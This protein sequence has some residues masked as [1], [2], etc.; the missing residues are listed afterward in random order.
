MIFFDEGV[1]A[2]RKL[3]GSAS[4][5]VVD[6]LSSP[7]ISFALVPYL[8][9][10]MGKEQYGVWILSISFLGLMQFVSLGSSA[11]LITEISHRQHSSRQ[12]SVEGLI[13]CSLAIALCGSAVLMILVWAATPFLPPG[14][15]GW[16]SDS[17]VQQVVLIAAVISVSEIDNIF[18]N[19]LRGLARFDVAARI[20]LI[21]RVIWALAV[22]IVTA[23]DGSAIGVLFVTLCLTLFKAGVKACALQQMLGSHMPIWRPKFSR[24]DAYILVSFGGWALIHALAGLFFFSADRW[25]IAGT[26]GVASLATYSICLQLAQIPHTL[27]SAGLQVIAPFVGRMVGKGNSV[28]FSYHGMRIA[29]WAAA[30]CLLVPIMLT[31]F[32]PIIL[33]NWIS[34]EFSTQNLDLSILLLLGFT[35]LCI[36]IPSHFML[37]GLGDIRF[38]SLL[39]LIAGG[40]CVALMLSLNLKNL[41]EFAEVRIVYGILLLITWWRLHKKLR[42]PLPI[43]S[44]S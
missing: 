4:W 14:L 33:K 5:S 40:V 17:L 34:P 11:A 27:L 39:N 36:N 15:P 41:S 21:V 38:V 12:G 1:R 20:E 18:A 29:G 26:L 30:L 9:L 16:G 42:S 35:V 23:V 28:K 22:V 37:V 32:T 6:Q 31:V 10:K 43:A 2:T 19:S 7:F 3:I 44:V 25:L 13:R 8:L 24:S